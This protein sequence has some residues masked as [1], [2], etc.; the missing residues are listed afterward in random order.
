MS[1]GP[2]DMGN[3]RQG[4]G[5]LLGQGH[6]SGPRPA[7]PYR[8]DVSDV[9]FVAVGDVVVLVL[10]PPR[11]SV[12]RGDVQLAVPEQES[13]FH[14][15]LSVGEKVSEKLGVE[16]EPGD[17]VFMAGGHRIETIAGSVWFT[18]AEHILSVIAKR[19][20]GPDSLIPTGAA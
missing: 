8:P 11:E 5:V 7:A 14:V 19:S 12:D 6:R 4:P 2:F 1:T 20:A 13:H 17:V 18:R 10:A 3:G 9:D 15:V 16:L